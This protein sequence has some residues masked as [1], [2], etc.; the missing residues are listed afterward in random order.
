MYIVTYEF[1]DPSHTL[2]KKHRAEVKE[3]KQALATANAQTTGSHSYRRDFGKH[4]EWLLAGQG[5]EVPLRISL[6]SP[7]AQEEDTVHTLRGL[8]AAKNKVAFE[9]GLGHYPYLLYGIY[10]LLPIFHKRGLIDAGIIAVP[11]QELARQLP[12]GIS[13]F[14]Q[15]TADLEAR[16]PGNLD[17]PVLVLGFTPDS[18]GST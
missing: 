14:E 17:I 5:W 7:G 15:V 1:A 10:G 6:R 11:T 18:I 9:L 8:D 16:G 3:I 2:A 13:Y 12:S 4:L